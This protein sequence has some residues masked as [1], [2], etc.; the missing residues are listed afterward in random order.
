MD[1]DGV[2]AAAGPPLAPL[3]TRTLLGIAS[4]S[5]A[6]PSEFESWTAVQ[7]LV[8]TYGRG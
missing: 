3:M 5:T 7:V 8:A 1:S 6:R 4:A 2:S